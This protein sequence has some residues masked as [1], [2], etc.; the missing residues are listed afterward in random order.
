LKFIIKDKY[1][2]LSRVIAANHCINLYPSSGQCSHLGKARLLNRLAIGVVFSIL[3]HCHWFLSLPAM[4]IPTVTSDKDPSCLFDLALCFLS[5]FALAFP[6][7]R[8][9]ISENVRAFIGFTVFS[10][11]EKNY[12]FLF[13]GLNDIALNSELIPSLG[14]R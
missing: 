3:S 14:F 1:Q 6:L 13:S 10:L 5:D 4:F 11:W 12:E 2:I 9:L 7:G 8:M